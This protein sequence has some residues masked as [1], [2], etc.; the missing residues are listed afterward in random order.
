MTNSNLLT[1]KGRAKRF[2]RPTAVEPWTGIYD[3]TK[4]RAAC[5][6]FGAPIEHNWQKNWSRIEDEGDKVK[7]KG[8]INQLVFLTIRRLLVSE[9]LEAG[10]VQSQ[11]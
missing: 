10:G 7:Q 4:W 5:P 8:S 2:S 9:C 3:A 6:Q 11:P 1:I